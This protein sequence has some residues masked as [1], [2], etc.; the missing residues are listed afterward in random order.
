V[1]GNLLSE[2]AELNR[3]ART[4]ELEK[5]D[6][7]QAALDFSHAHKVPKYLMNQVLK[8]TRFHHDHSSGDLRKKDFLDHLPMSL[9]RSLVTVIF[10]EALSKVPLF[11]LLHSQDESFLA[12]VWSYM[13]YNTYDPGTAIIEA[14]EP[15]RRLLV[16]VKGEMTVYVENEDDC[17]KESY[18]LKPGDYIGDYALLDDTNWSASTL[19]S[20]S[21]SPEAYVEVYTA[22]THFVVCLELEATAFQAIVEAHSFH[23]ISTITYLKRLRLEHQTSPSGKAIFHIHMV[24]ERWERLAKGLLGD[25]APSD[26]GSFRKRVQ[27][28]LES[29]HTIRKLSVEPDVADLEVDRRSARTRAALECTNSSCSEHFTEEIADGSDLQLAYARLKRQVVQQEK[30]IHEL[31]AKLELTSQHAN[32]D[33]PR[34]LQASTVVTV[35]NP[36]ESCVP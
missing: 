31:S 3:A 24:M 5:M 23:V 36:T 14:G 4:E 6:R 29:M 19:I 34:D 28:H 32:G 12:E 2:L 10:G 21:C 13:K 8:W 27:Q 33:L 26:V 9:K 30:Y 35:A 7:V 16:V 22:D 20:A 1:F 18:V 11:A 25:T 15:A 17:K